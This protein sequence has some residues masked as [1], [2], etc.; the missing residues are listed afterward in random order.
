M[1]SNGKQLKDNVYKE[2]TGESIAK[3]KNA[4]YLND[5][6]KSMLRKSVSP[7][8]AIMKEAMGDYKNMEV[9]F[10]RGKNKTP[11]YTNP[12]MIPVAQ[13][14][15]MKRAIYEIVK[16]KT[17]S[18]YNENNPWA[19]PIFGLPKKNDGVRIVSDFRKLNEAIKCN[20]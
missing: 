10:E 17:V 11:Y 12:Y 14:N 9:A 16:N 6:E 5:V 19:T 15:L 2:N 4:E 3:H 18:E 1:A 13:I 20:P 8:I 7:F